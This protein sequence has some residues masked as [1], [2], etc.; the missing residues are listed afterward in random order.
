MSNRQLFYWSCQTLEITVFFLN[1]KPIC[2]I[3][4][5]CPFSRIN[6]LPFNNCSFS[7]IN[8]VNL[9]QRKTLSLGKNFWH[10]IFFY[11]YHNSLL[12]QRTPNMGSKATNKQTKCGSNTYTNNNYHT[13]KKSVS[14]YN[15]CNQMPPV[16]SS[17]DR[18]IKGPKDF[19]YC[20]EVGLRIFSIY[21]SI[22]YNK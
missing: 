4:Y 15:K 16:L 17:K 11:I 22:N 13:Q 8:G 21:F 3:F 7:S 19:I 12:A 9:T 18:L 2:Y 1:C 14:Q 6:R 20:E 10:P 5:N